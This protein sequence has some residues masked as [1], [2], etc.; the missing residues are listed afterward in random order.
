MKDATACIETKEA[1]I[2]QL[3]RCLSD[4]GVLSSAAM[5]T[6]QSEVDLN[7]DISGTA[8]AADNN[9]SNKTK[10]SVPISPAYPFSYKLS[11][12]KDRSGGPA[13]TSGDNPVVSVEHPPTASQAGFVNLA[14]S[15]K[16]LQDE[17]IG[18]RGAGCSDPSV[19]TSRSQSV[20]LQNVTTGTTTTT[21]PPP[22][23]QGRRQQK[24]SHI[25]DLPN[26]NYMGNAPNVDLSRVFLDK[27]L[28][29]TATTT[30]K[31]CTVTNV[32]PKSSNN[33][34]NNA[35][36]GIGT[37]N[38]VTTST[39]SA[40][41]SSSKRSL[42]Q[43]LE[44]RTSNAK[45]VEEFKSNLNDLLGIHCLAMSDYQTMVGGE[46]LNQSL[47]VTSAQPQIVTP[48]IGSIQTSPRSVTTT[49]TTTTVPSSTSTITNIR[50]NSNIL[51]RQVQDENPAS[52]HKSHR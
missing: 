32:G 24:K 47:A 45:E 19:T 36:K 3:V 15:G 30:S 23:K 28:T 29:T 26:V 4:S 37:V 16:V 52:V 14:K 21:A 18:S 46:N 31:S 25:S 42:I 51:E 17:G 22:P 20:P 12:L 1:Q 8:A 10:K 35:N 38:V 44:D 39:P 48:S 41:S 7:Q 49:T 27:L 6:S 50:R 13:I 34:S 2:P 43:L 11:L 9:L 33:N 40:S 5:E